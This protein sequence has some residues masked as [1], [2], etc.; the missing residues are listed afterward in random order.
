MK[1]ATL[2]IAFLL[3]MSGVAYGQK[4]AELRKTLLYNEVTEESVVSNRAAQKAYAGA[5]QVID[6]RHAD[7]FD[8]GRAKGSE[9]FSFY[10]DPRP[11][12]EAAVPGKVLLVWVVTPDGRV[13]EP[14]ILHSTDARLASHVQGR[15]ANRRYVPARLRGT[16]VFSLRGHEFVFGPAGKQSRDSMM[17]KDGLGIQGQRDR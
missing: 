9:P 5:F 3:S 17:F 15:V 6:I 13:I 10:I 12:R 16:A 8:P 7:G 1:Y 4:A 2:A 11:E 14:R